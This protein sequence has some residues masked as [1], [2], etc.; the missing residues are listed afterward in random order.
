MG[1]LRS[2]REQ[3]RRPDWLAELQ[4]VI[5][6]GL[7]LIGVTVAVNVVA[8]AA[9]EQV[10]VALPASAVDGLVGLSGGLRDGATVAADS[11]VDVWLADPGA[12]DVFWYAALGLPQLVLIAAVLALLLRL[13]VAARRGDPFTATTVRRLR[14]LGAV[15]AVGGVLVGVIG[16]VAELAL[17]D[18]ASG[19][20]AVTATLTLNPVWILVGGGFLAFGEIV[21]RGRALRAELDTVI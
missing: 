2:V 16:T 6:V 3:L 9:G 19:G 17:T 5:V 10:V 12:A 18:R 1:T 7:A 13:I 8:L 11:T 14:V 4:L 21:N 15:S 20:D